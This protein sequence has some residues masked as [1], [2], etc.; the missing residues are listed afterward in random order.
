[1]LQSWRLRFIDSVHPLGGT[2]SAPFS[3]PED[4]TGTFRSK[5]L[6]TVLVFSLVFVY[7]Y[8]NIY[9]L[10]VIAHTI[11]LYENSSRRGLSVIRF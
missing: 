7:I 5:Y 9:I 4:C 1:M 8:L 3:G 10:F 6:P 11:S 2:V